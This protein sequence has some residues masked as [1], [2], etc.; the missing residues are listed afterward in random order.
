MIRDIANFR[1]FEIEKNKDCF[2]IIYK[3]QKLLDVFESD[4]D[5][6]E[7]LGTRQKKP[8]NKFKNPKNPTDEEKAIRSEIERYN[9]LIT[10]KQ[11]IPY[12]KINGI[13][14]EVLNFLMFEIRDTGVSYGSEVIKYQYVV[15]MCLVHEDE[16]DTEYGINRVDLLSYLVK[17]LLCW[18]NVLGM[19]MKCES[20]VD[21]IVDGNYYCRTLKFRIDTTNGGLHPGGNKYDRFQRI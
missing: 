18:S 9:E 6:S 11:I 21:S 1:D 3:K 4:P 16:M 2:D 17:D 14:K 12:L 10:H 19:R 20:D 8:L 5:V 7:I 13:Q 15:V